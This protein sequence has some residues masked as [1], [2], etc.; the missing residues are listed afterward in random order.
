MVGVGVWFVFKEIHIV[1]AEDFGEK[2]L[3]N[4]ILFS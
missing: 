2:S 4:W 3:L 1:V